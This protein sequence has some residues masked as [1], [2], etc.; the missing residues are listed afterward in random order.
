MS[1]TR[2]G[3]FLE[4]VLRTSKLT[5]CYGEK[6]AVDTVSMQIK[7][8]DIYGFIGKN[9]AGKTTLMRLVL[10]TAMPNSGKIELFGSM[11]I[12]NQRHRI[13]SLLEYPCLYKNCSAAENLKRFAMLTKSKPADIKLILK[14]VGLSDTGKKPAGEFSLG[15]KQRLGIGIALLGN[16]E[17]L[18]LD[19]PI[20]GLD[21]AGIK[22]IRDIILTLNS[23]L[24][25][26]FLISS[27]LLDEL[28]KI[29]TTYGIIN[30]GK[31]IEQ[32]SA[33]QLNDRC[34]HQMRIAVDDTE[35]A[36][37]IL[38]AMTD[39][40]T[41]STDGNTVY[42]YSLIDRSAEVCGSLVRGGVNVGELVIQ[43]DRLEE[44][45]I[46]RLGELR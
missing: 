18:I 36:V 28:A 43:S 11:D 41:I 40:N 37:N 22:E 2:G 26:T 45:F 14:L 6:K 31:L 20:N 16:P 25:V 4:Y 17:F 10:G 39:P 33:A 44:Y 3:D 29:V 46:E 35:K 13:G 32:I 8:G 15:M 30:D 23:Q 27:H 21:P 9:G 7:K 42:L 1:N 19:E 5:K 24:G 12:A 34:R 38:S